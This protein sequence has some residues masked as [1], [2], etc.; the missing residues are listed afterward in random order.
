MKNN[1]GRGRSYPSKLKAEADNSYQVRRFAALSSRGKKNLGPGYSNPKP[2]LKGEASTNA[3]SNYEEGVL[4]TDFTE[5]FVAF[6]K[7]ELV[8]NM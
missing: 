7:I 6:I 1:Q 3:N 5:H 4:H 8:S 2:N